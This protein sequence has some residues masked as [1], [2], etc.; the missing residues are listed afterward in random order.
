MNNR[1]TLPTPAALNVVYG[2]TFAFIVLMVIALLA[3]GCNSAVVRMAEDQILVPTTNVVATPTNWVESVATTNAAGEVTTTNVQFYATNILVNVTY[4]VSTNAVPVA[5]TI[6]A[7]VNAFVPGLGELMS[8]ILLGLLSL[9]AKMKSNRNKAVQTTLVQSVETLLAIIE[10]TP[11]GALMRDRLRVE[12]N[13]SQVAAG[14]VAEVA[15]LV[16]K[17]VD[18]DAAKRSAKLILESLPK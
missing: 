17:Y 9:W 1:N 3:S 4:A 7:T 10:S 13:K 12:L 5:K 6:G 8:V 11:Q 2:A 14:I 18:N 16:D 15:A